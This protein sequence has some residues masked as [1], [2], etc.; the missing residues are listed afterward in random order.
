MLFDIDAGRLESQ[1]QH[2]TLQMKAA[3]PPIGVQANPL[4]TIE[5]TLTT[6][7]IEEE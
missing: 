2:Y 1:R 4:I 7:L 5:Q 3:L 6:E